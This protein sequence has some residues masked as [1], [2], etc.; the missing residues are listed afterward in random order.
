MTELVAIFTELGCAEIQT[1][2]QS[3]NVVFRAQPSF[4]RRIPDLVADAIAR[5]FGYSVPLV[6]RTAAEL[7][8]A[9]AANPVPA[10]RRRP[11]DPPHGLSCE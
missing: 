2:I 10:P 5:R 11:Q 6:M 1:Y 3:G 9:A 4:A 7:R 8:K